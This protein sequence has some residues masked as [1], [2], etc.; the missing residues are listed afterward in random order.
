MEN[1][2]IRISIARDFTSLPGPRYIREGTFSG[3]Q[4]RTE[5]LLPAFEQALVSK[6]KIEVLLDGTIGYGTS[7]L[8]ESFGGLVR[9]LAKQRPLKEAIH[10]VLNT[11]QIIS[12][13]E[14]YLV[15]DVKSYIQNARF[16]VSATN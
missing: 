1:N 10:L 2:T 4:F 5:K 8:E 6:Q 16:P 3:E 12:L 7:F 9:E 14:D 15:E 13:E 11:L